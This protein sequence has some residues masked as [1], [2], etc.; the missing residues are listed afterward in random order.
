MRS[1]EKIWK[2]KFTIVILYMLIAD[3]EPARPRLLR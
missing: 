3:L 2:A 1:Y